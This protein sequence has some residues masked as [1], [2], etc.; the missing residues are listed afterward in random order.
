MSAWP[1]S[2]NPE[3][4]ELL[5]SWMVR[6]AHANGLGCE[7]FVTIVFG[8][9]HPIWVRDID[10]SAD[11]AT[12][13]KL[14]RIS[15]V[16]EERLRECTLREVEWLVCPTGT[17]R[18]ANVGLLPLGIYHRARRR[19]GLMF[20]PLC[21]AGDRD[22][23]FRRSW[24][25]T[26]LASCTQHDVVLRDRCVCG[27]PVAPHRVDVRWYQHTNSN[28][29]LHARC[30]SCGMALEAASTAAATAPLRMVSK[31]VQEALIERFVDF[32]SGALFAPAFFQGV[33]ALMDAQAKPRQLRG[34]APQL[35]SAEIRGAQLTTVGQWL[36]DWP[37]SFLAEMRRHRLTYTD[38]RRGRITLP[39]W[40][41]S[42]ARAMLMIKSQK[43]AEVEIAAMYKYLDD[44]RGATSPR[45]AV[46][47]LGRFVDRARLPPRYR[48]EVSDECYEM[49]LAHLDQDV[50][51]HFDPRQRAIV[52]AD[53]TWL[54]LGCAMQMPLTRLA[55][56]SVSDLRAL[57]HGRCRKSARA[58]R[59][60]EEVR[61]ILKCYL[62]EVR[63][64]LS[65]ETDDRTAFVSITGRGGLSANGLSMRLRKYLL[66]AGL[67]RQVPS[68]SGLMK[69]V[70][71]SRHG[72]ISLSAN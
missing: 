16:R 30:W 54:A 40:I 37:E 19:N 62:D 70:A 65:C 53:K 35:L 2:R 8:R 23:Y 4:D 61:S 31:L 48:R 71:P 20:C 6:L 22:P 17:V 15:G 57:A 44:M 55:R 41:D 42:V 45:H 39:H 25:V 72:S 63:P 51:S 26:Y 5:S 10:R 9:Q 52:L 28:S 12:L 68:Y 69:S 60:I 3:Q 64:L 32:G 14:S 50:G 59:T 56:L 18:G 21:L 24:R 11:D 29:T 13:A 67:D 7:P 46:E 49:L 47:M 27:A 33:R 66:R 58:P 43:H 38:L 34:C 36:S 1:I